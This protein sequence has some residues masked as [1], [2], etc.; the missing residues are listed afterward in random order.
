WVDKSYLVLSAAEAASASL[1]W[2]KI[3]CRKT[4]GSVT[5]GRASYSHLLC[6]SRRALPVSI[7]PSADVLCD[8]SLGPWSNAMSV[9][10][11]RVACQ[12]FVEQSGTRLVV[13]PFCGRG[14]ALAVANRFGFDALGVDHS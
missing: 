5:H 9:E 1:I 2:H 4:P 8:T 7:P 14:T 3:V 13:D 11:C 10:A 12:F 6:L